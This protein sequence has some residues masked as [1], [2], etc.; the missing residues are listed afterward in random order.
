LGCRRIDY[1]YDNLGRQT[2][3]RSRVGTDPASS[4]TNEVAYTYSDSAWGQL[5]KVAQAH[6]GAADSSTPAMQ[7]TWEDGAV[8]GIAKY[9]RQAT[10]IYPNGRV[11]TNQ[12]SAGMDSALS[13]LSSVAGVGDPGSG[14]NALIQYTYLGAGTIVELAHP[15]ATSSGAAPTG[16]SL[17]LSYGSSGSYPG[18]DRFGRVLDQKWTVS[19]NIMDRFQYTHDRLGN[20]IAR[21]QTWMSGLAENESYVYDGLQQLTNMVRASSLGGQ[22]SG[23]AWS[24]GF[25][26][27]AVGSQLHGQGGWKGWDNNGAYGALVSSNQAYA[28]AKCVAILGASDLVHTYSGATNGIWTYTARQFVPTNFS[29]RQ[30]FILLNKY[31]DGGP[32]NWSIQVYFDSA[33]NK[34]VSDFDGANV[35]LIKGRWVDIRVEINLNTDIQIFYYGATKLYQ[36][37]WTGGVSGGGTRNIAAVDLYANNASVIY[38]DQISLVSP[39]GFAAAYAKAQGWTLEPAGNW[40]Q[41]RDATNVENRAHNIFNEITG[42]NGDATAVTHDAAG[43]MVSL[44]G[45][46]CPS[47]TAD[48]NLNWDGWNRLARLS[49][50]SGAVI[51]TY[52]CDGDWKRLKKVVATNVTE[53]YYDDMQL[54]ETRQVGATGQVTQTQSLVYDTRYLHSVAYRDVYS[55]LT[56]TLVTRHAFLN[57][58]NFNVTALVSTNGTVVERYTYD[59]Y[60]KVTIRDAN[61]QPITWDVG[62]K[63]VCL[64]T[65]HKYDAESG[66]YYSLYRYYHP[67]LGR[68]TSRD[69]I[70]EIVFWLTTRAEMDQN[71][72]QTYF[73]IYYELRQLRV[74]SHQVAATWIAV[75]QHLLMSRKVATSKLHSSDLPRVHNVVENGRTTMSPYVYPN[76]QNR[77]DSTGLATLTLIPEPVAPDFYPCYLAT[78]QTPGLNEDYI[79]WHAWPGYREK[80]DKCKFAEPIAANSTRMYSDRA[81][82]IMVQCCCLTKEE[83]LEIERRV[84][85]VK[86]GTA[87]VETDPKWPIG[88]ARGDIITACGT[89][90]SWAAMGAL[91]IPDFSRLK[92]TDIPAAYRAKSGGGTHDL[93]NDAFATPHVFLKMLLDVKKCK[94]VVEVKPD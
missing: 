79:T 80:K 11:V 81:S 47:G 36:K 42:I 3:V 19:T 70:H 74:P 84:G 86:A 58:A 1:G 27:Y 32:Y 89:M 78:F 22:S 37:S 52:A 45:R 59:P 68:W 46:A 76:P 17:L 9:V 51:A 48:L 73:A 4:L 34:V 93:K 24:D 57:D 40:S 38:Y 66:L 28:G 26:S 12:Y 41:F 88:S 18:L 82:F 87:T 30:Y 67:G 92:E 7:Y 63:N 10:K 25:E 21:S 77:F 65:G 64:Y 39:S 85:V 43:N 29:G 49:T 8:A 35:P 55:G 6:T 50:T 72:L 75:R 62:Q 61:W 69:P 15:A 31:N 56:A 94:K 20:R 54:A 44:R 53:Y 23:S 16:R 33:Q 83:G 90:T 71:Q 13:R 5:T 91:G 2:F 14:T 60:G